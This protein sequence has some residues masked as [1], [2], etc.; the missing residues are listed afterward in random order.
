MQDLPIH[1][2]F[3]HFP[4]AL[5]FFSVVMDVL[6]VIKK[7]D[8]LRTIAQYG[9]IAGV[10]GGLA[11]MATG[12]ATA[13]VLEQKRFTWIT[14]AIKRGEI[15]AEIPDIIIQATRMLEAHTVTSLYTIGIFLGLLSW[16]LI[17]RRKLQGAELF[18]Y[19]T[20]SIVASIILVQTGFL[21]GILGHDLMPKVERL[22]VRSQAISGE[23][24]SGDA[25]QPGEISGS[26]GGTLSGGR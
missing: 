11:A 13:A 6:G 14:E 17:V 21:G 26:G 20:G 8:D 5:L 9:L 15:N 25:G 22:D 2:M 10:V 7:R 23:A 12:F 18:A 1:A 16:R 4:I 24:N 19:L 3:V